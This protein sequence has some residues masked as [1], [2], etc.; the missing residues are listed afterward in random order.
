[1]YDLIVIGG[2]PAGCAAAI[3]AA[4]ARRRVLLL[5]RGR[6][7]RQK[8]CGEFVSAESLGLLRSLFAD[9][10]ESLNLLERA[11]RIDGG[12]LFVDSTVLQAP[13]HP[14]AA[15]IS[16]Y[17][18]DEN[19]WHAALQT[20]VDARQ[21]QTVVALSGTGPFV[22]GTSAESFESRSVINATGRWSNLRSPDPANGH[23][24]KWIGLKAHFAEPSPPLSVDLYFFPGGYCG[25]QPVD[26]SSEINA[27]AMVRS[28]VATSLP[29]VFERHPA[30]R[31]RADKWRQMTDVVSTSP[32]VFKTP[33][34]T[35]HNVLMAGDAAG[36]VDPFVGDGISLALRSGT[37]AAQSLASF[38]EG[39]VALPD[40]AI[41][42]STSY[43]RQLLPIFR[44][45]STIRRLFAFPYPARA[46]LLFL[47]GHTPA[48]TRYLVR[49]TR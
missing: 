14:A 4:R 17:V 32:L 35:P 26:H 12:R 33:D 46:A 18:L 15:S 43:T 29:E 24:A 41:S 11:P 34:P 39:N 20:G 44:T 42:Y 8:V 49:K 5:E 16:R 1:M 38:W 31:N 40:A 3:T 22:V 47:F 9:S 6:Y 10:A 21:Q 28:D 25:V 7:P 37:L 36:F 13:V 48:L 19:L 30:L 23:R 45:S 27:C 2:G